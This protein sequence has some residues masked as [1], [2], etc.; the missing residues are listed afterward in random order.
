MRR[1]VTTVRAAANGG[2]SA[3]C[4]PL[5]FPAR[6]R[7]LRWVPRNTHVLAPSATCWENAVSRQKGYDRWSG[8]SPLRRLYTAS[9]TRLEICSSGAAQAYITSARRAH[10]IASASRGGHRCVAAALS[11]LQG[12]GTSR[13]LPPDPHF[14]PF[15]PCSPDLYGILLSSFASR[16]SAIDFRATPPFFLHSRRIFMCFP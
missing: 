16:L 9:Y 15:L 10:T 11:A 6:C 12:F 8:E 14:S 1:E 13:F 2:A 7:R 5:V 4:L 3:K